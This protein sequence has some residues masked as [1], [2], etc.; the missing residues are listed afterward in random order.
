MQ[1][2]NR[3]RAGVFIAAFLAL[4]AMA[5]GVA[6]TVQA[7]TLNDFI[8]TV[9]T[10]NPGSS[11]STA[12]TIPTNGAGYNYN[13]DCDNDTIDE[14]SAQTTA[15]TCVYPVAG[16]YTIVISGTFPQIFFNYA[17]DVEKLLSVDQWG[18]NVWTSMAF[19]FAG[20]VNMNVIATDVPNLSSVTSMS[21]MFNEAA[22]FN[23]DISAWDVSNVTDMSGM[24]SGALAFNQNI[25]GWNTSNVTNMYA[26]FVAA[27]AFNQNIGSWDVSQVTDMSY[28]FKTASAFNQNIGSWNT[29]RV[30]NMSHMFEMASNFNQNISAWNTASTTDMSRM[31]YKA[32]AFNQNIGSWNIGRVIDMTLLLQDS[33]MSTANYDLALIGWSS[34]VVEPDVPLDVGALTYCAVGAHNTLTAPPNAWTITDGGVASLCSSANRYVEFSVETAASTNEAVADNFPL[35]LVDGIFADP[36]SVVV[37]ITGGTAVNGTDFVY[38]VTTTVTIPSGTYDGTTSTAIAL[39]AF[40]ILNNTL[41]DGNRTIIFSLASLTS[42]VTVNDADGNDSVQ[43]GHTYTITDDDVST[44]GSCT[45]NCGGGTAFPVSSA[46]QGPLPVPVIPVAPV[47]VPTPTPAGEVLGEKISIIDELI[48]KYDCYTY[49]D[50]I[51]QL[52]IELQKQGYFPADFVPTRY[53]GNMTRAAVT[54]YLGDQAPSMT[55]D[56]LVKFAFKLGQRNEA[57]KRLQTELKALGF[58]P[59]TVPATGYR[60][61]ITKAAIAKYKAAHK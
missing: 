39:P 51:R 61:P 44:G 60:G 55:V 34:Q 4:G 28:M 37:T 14:F 43:S 25:G 16:T 58:F 19:A 57:V 38:P 49:A 5:F 29:A 27:L 48:L 7:A 32:S 56:E 24:F 22:V 23:H 6:Q 50:G 13:V 41:V 2:K 9:K 15:V 12:F 8:I 42:G 33:G 30:V 17:G 21:G 59:A 10:D 46:S 45:N 54:K 18:T 3:N 31:F 53:Y 1:V 20:A 11:S 26:M 52:Q 35:L 36:A 47:V 40:A